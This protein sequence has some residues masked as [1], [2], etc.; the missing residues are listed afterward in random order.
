MLLFPQGRSKLMQ[1]F[2]PLH[3]PHPQAVWSV[4]PA[5]FSTVMKSS[6][7]SY[8]TSGIW[9]LKYS[10]IWRMSSASCAQGLGVGR[11]WGLGWGWGV[12]RASSKERLW[13]QKAAGV[14]YEAA[15]GRQTRTNL[16]STPQCGVLLQLSILR[17]FVIT[18]LLCFRQ[19][20]QH[21]T[22]TTNNSTPRHTTPHHSTLPLPSPCSPPKQ[23][24]AAAPPAP[25]R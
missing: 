22:H 15:R 2:K 17:C 6:S 24:T 14:E 9:R 7:F 4:R 11:G 1:A 25:R 20:K 13:S 21:S 3:R 18:A 8:L 12:S 19:H 16:L 23:N 5:W 10:P